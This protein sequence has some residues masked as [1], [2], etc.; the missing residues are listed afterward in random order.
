MTRAHVIDTVQGIHEILV[1]LA[2]FMFFAFLL[3][4]LPYLKSATRYYNYKI[5]MH[6][7]TMHLRVQPGHRWL[8]N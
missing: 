3:R 7:Q 5:A 2:V 1:L 6:E 4:P 8:R